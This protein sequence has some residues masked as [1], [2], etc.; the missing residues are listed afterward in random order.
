MLARCGITRHCGNQLSCLFYL[1]GGDIDKLGSYLLDFTMHFWLI[2]VCC[3]CLHVSWCW[4][5]HI[6]CSV[7]ITVV[8]WHLSVKKAT[9]SVKMDN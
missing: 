4:L 9:S 6:C 1:L 8:F 3:Y 2:V 5:Y 7:I